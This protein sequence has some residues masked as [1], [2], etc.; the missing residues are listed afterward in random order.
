MKL[1]DQQQTQA[2][3]L[4]APNVRLAAVD[5]LYV[6]LERNGIVVL[7]SIVS[8]EQLRD[9]QHAFAARLQHLRWNNF[10]GYQRTEVYR[11]MVED[12]LV[13]AQGFVDLAVHPLVKK[14]LSRYLGATYQLTEAKGWQ[15]LPTNYDFHGWHGDTWYEQSED[16]PIHREVKLAMYLTD[17]RSGAFN[18]IRGSHR[19]QHPHNLQRAEVERLQ[20]S[21]RIELKGPAGTVFLFD[22]SVIHRQ[23]LPIREPRQAIFYAYHDASVQLQHEDIAYYRYHPLLL[24]AAFLGDLSED[25]QRVL[26]F[27]DKRNYQ[28]AF[29]R[30]GEL[31]FLHRAFNSANGAHLRL[32][33]LR[34]RVVARLRRMKG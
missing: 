23:G 28:P 31:S 30:K 5:A 15:S 1:Y 34:Q 10:D 24:N 22:T 4:R 12:I 25:D 26:G 9:M 20:M 13:L 17:V 2:E 32:D 27:G 33:Q 8:D 29:V 19:Q 16:V 6:E 7:P 3:P 21:E 11:R 18:V 14:L